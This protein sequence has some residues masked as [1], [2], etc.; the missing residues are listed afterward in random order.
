M[1]RIVHGK[2]LFFVIF[3]ELISVFCVILCLQEAGIMNKDILRIAIP[4]I[5]ANI[6]VPLLGLIDTG[7][8]GHLGRTEYIGAMSVGALMFNLVYWNFGFLRMGTS[9]ITAQFVGGGDIA[10]ACRTLL[11]ASALALVIATAI[12]ALQYPLQWLAILAISPSAEVATLAKQYFFIGVWGAPAVLTM[13]AVKGWFLGLQDSRTP[14]I[15]S[16]AVNVINIVASFTAVYAFDAGFTGIAAGTIIAEYSGLLLSAFFVIRKHGRDL[17]TAGMSSSLKRSS[18][19]KFFSVNRDIFLRS[20]CLMAVTL[21]FTAI[22]ARSGDVTLAAN[23]LMIQLFIL[24]SY[25]MDGF[26]FAGEALVGKYYG[27]RAYG[28][29]RKCVKTLFVWGV[30]V[31]AIFTIA[32]TFFAHSI[33]HL[34]TDDTAVIERAEEYRL[35]CMV[36]PAAGMAGF[37]WDGIF[38]GLTATRDMLL[39]IAASCLLFFAICFLPVGEICNHRLWAAFISYLAMRGALQT[40]LYRRHHP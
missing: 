10:G 29:L 23:A 21:S 36:I 24:F 15:I 13:M 37:L 28:E 12:I 3:G 17:K 39:S 30:A 38:I 4:S 16:I 32:Y 19:G 7:I 22:G 8:A 2:T 5:V 26:S 20:V 34:L 14:M 18:L 35:W 6:T 9:G 1:C 27:A 11:R 33:F 31:M 40:L 25:F